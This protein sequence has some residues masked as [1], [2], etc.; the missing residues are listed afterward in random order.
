MKI[1]AII[2][3]LIRT[4]GKKISYEEIGKAIGT[5]KQNISYLVK[6]NSELPPEK[7]KDIENYFS[8]DFTKVKD[9]PTASWS[10]K[11]G[12]TPAEYEELLKVLEKDKYKIFICLRAIAGDEQALKDLKKLFCD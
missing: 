4:T 2:E 12:L 8:V 6:N 5:T 7:L 9:Q 10:D 11:L 3:Y 1:Q